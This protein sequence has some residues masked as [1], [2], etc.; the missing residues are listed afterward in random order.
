VEKVTASEEMDW[1]MGGYGDG[2]KLD[3]VIG[4]WGDRKK[5]EKKRR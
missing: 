1:E 2:G 5:D 4:R 3:R